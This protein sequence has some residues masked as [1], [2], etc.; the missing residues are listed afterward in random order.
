MR[1]QAWNTS[2]MIDRLKIPVIVTKL[3]GLGIPFSARLQKMT[4]GAMK[5]IFPSKVML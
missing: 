2:I 4:G 3:C 1:L 5:T